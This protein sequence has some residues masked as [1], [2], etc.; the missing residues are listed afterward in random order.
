[1]TQNKYK[2]TV[3][4]YG[5]FKQAEYFSLLA[6]CRF[7]IYLSESE[8][9]GL[10]MFE[11]WARNIPTLVWE[12]GFWQTEKYYWQ[13]MTASPYLSD[14]AGMRF[15]D[16]AEFQRI[17]REFVTRPFSPRDYVSENFTNAICAKKYLEILNG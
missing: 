15:A 10:A 17:F 14:K 12:R 3:L 6:Q 9:Q 1:L 8:S 11:A 7:E 16:F 2:F 13:G 4:E 5:Q